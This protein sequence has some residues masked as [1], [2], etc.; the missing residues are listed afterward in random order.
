MGNLGARPL[1]YRSFPG[2]VIGC[3]L[4]WG[5]GFVIGHEL[6][7][8]LQPFLACKNGFGEQG[9]GLRSILDFRVLKP[10]QQFGKL[11]AGWLT[12]DTITGI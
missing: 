10:F 8:S 1:H 12:C 4:F 5:L 9:R 2:R 3:V 7:E 6:L 11:F